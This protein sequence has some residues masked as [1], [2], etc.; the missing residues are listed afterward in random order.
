M[1][2][3]RTTARTKVVNPSCFSARQVPSGGHLPGDCGEGAHQSHGN[4][5]PAADAL[6]HL[7]YRHS[8]DR[9]RHVFCQVIIYC[10]PMY[11][12]VD[13]KLFCSDPDPTFRE[14]LNPDPT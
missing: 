7:R 2:H 14:I 3:Y 11:S 10:L 12:V 5:S 9:P 4:L 6:R 13:P 1:K 8:P